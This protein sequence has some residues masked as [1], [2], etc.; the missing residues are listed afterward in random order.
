MRWSETRW[1]LLPTT[2]LTPT[3]AF[4]SLSAGMSE[5]GGNYEVFRDCISSAILEEYSNAPQ[6]KKVRRPRKGTQRA[7]PST[8]RGSENGET[9]AAELAEFIEVINLSCPST[10]P[11]NPMSDTP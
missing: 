3:P 11:S 6:K 10:H 9:D 5:D 2:I 1:V 7:S 8:E 4:E